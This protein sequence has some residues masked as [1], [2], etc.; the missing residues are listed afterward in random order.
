MT[1]VWL[2]LA[3]I[4]TVLAA[5]PTTTTANNN[6]SSFW[7]S[8][9]IIIRIPIIILAPVNLALFIIL[10]RWFFSWY[11]KAINSKSVTS[12]TTKHGNLFSIWNYDGTIAYEDIIRSTNDFDIEHCIGTGSYGSVYKAQLPSGKVVAVKKLHGFEA[13]EPAFYKSFKN[14]V[15]VLSNI[16]HK[17]IVKLYGFCLHNRCMFLVYDYL[18]RE[19]LFCVLRDDVEAVELEWSKRVDVV[20]GIAHALSYM[21]HDCTP[22]IVHRDIS[23][24]NIL[25]NTKLEAFV[26]D[27]GAA[28]LLSPDSSNQTLIAGTYGY[29]APELAYTK[30]ITEKCDVYS[31]GVVALEIIMGKHP[32]DLLLSLTSPSK[33]NIVV[34]DLLDPRL[35]RPTDRLVEWD[36]VLIM[37]PLVLT[38]IYVAANIVLAPTSKTE[39]EALLGSRWWGRVITVDTSASYCNWEDIICKD[40][41]ETVTSIHPRKLLLSLA[42]LTKLAYL[43]I[44]SNNISSTIPFG[45]PSFPGSLTNL[46]DFYLCKNK[47]MG[48]IPSSLTNLTH[49]EELDLSKNQHTGFIPLELGKLESSD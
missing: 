7:S 41:E 19:S 2:P 22:T 28:R 9:P 42:N 20:K 44:Y 11:N 30:V 17:N 36:I 29:I 5:A 25:L 45:I 34:N 13:K 27:F 37:S 4:I 32:G 48:L 8:S 46:T 18:E 47:L 43:D 15:L 14:E 31:F 26:A 12:V 35:S 33:L 40:D 38:A 1:A 3:A 21:H 23:S 39:A 24:N 49:L 10:V 16:R 6:F